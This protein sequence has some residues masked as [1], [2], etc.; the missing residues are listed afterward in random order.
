M[1]LWHQVGRQ[2]YSVTQLIDNDPSI[3]MHIEVFSRCAN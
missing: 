2:G 1:G 3:N